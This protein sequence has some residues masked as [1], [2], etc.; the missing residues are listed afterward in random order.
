MTG[1]QTCALPIY[2]GGGWARAGE[3]KLA[4]SVYR[5]AIAKQ[6]QAQLPRSGLAKVLSAQGKLKKS[7]EILKLPTDKRNDFEARS[8]L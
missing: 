1:V 3:Y 4:A 2:L 8:F 5:Q 6:P 7:A